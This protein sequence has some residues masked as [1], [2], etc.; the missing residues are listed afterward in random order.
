M[1]DVT[2]VRQ[3]EVHRCLS[4]GRQ[5]P[6]GRLA[7]NRQGVFFQYDDA[8]C[9][10]FHSLAP[11]QLAFDTR[12]QAAPR[13]PHRGLHGMFADSLPDGWG[14]MLMDRL[15]R[16]HGISPH[17]L[18]PMDRLAFVGEHG[19][20]A[21][22]YYPVSELGAD[23]E[24]TPESSL[25]ELGEQA[26]RLFEGQTDT[27]LATLAQA[28]S[29]FVA[30]S[31]TCSP[32]TRTI[33]ARTGRSCWTIRAN[34]THPRPTI[35]PSA[36]APT[37]NTPPP[38]TGM[39][40]PRPSR[41]CK[42]WPIRPVSHA[43]AKRDR[44]SRKSSRRWAAGAQPPRRWASA[45]G[46]GGKYSGGWTPLSR[47]TARSGGA[48][49]Q[50]TPALAD[51][52]RTP[53]LAAGKDLHIRLLAAARPA[54]RSAQAGYARPRRISHGTGGFAGHH[55]A[56]APLLYSRLV[57]RRWVRAQDRFAHLGS[58]PSTSASARSKS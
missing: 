41:L 23:S 11:F 43:G 32:A 4:D 5:V 49:G 34:G 24:A 35:S 28:G 8:Y 54:V 51:A 13:T 50:D 57:Q 1:R 53:H 18:T 42:H 21:L 3:L 26:R 7:Q 31:L 52:E 48:K 36:R 16:Q 22:R 55:G 58:T 2:P 29:C 56:P 40:R 20:G 27:V 39:A 47:Q 25:S 17:D 30:P 37:V 9:Q 45:P 15:F 38:S 12:L 33:T 46:Y 10:A 19:M 6:V 44:R 14:M